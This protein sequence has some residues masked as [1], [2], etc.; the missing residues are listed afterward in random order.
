M[1]SPHMRVFSAVV[2]AAAKRALLPDRTAHEFQVKVGTVAI[3]VSGDE[4]RA[5]GIVPDDAAVHFLLGKGELEGAA[6]CI[7]AG[8][9]L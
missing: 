7:A 6:R 1:S 5:E 4:E 3:A 8:H 9:E 2:S